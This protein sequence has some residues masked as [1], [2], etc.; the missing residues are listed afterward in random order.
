MSMW[1]IAVG[2]FY[3]ILPTKAIIVGPFLAIFGGECVLQSTIIT[4]TSALAG[5]YVQRYV[6]VQPSFSNTSLIHCRASYFSY[7]SSTSYVVSFMG[8]TLASITMSWNIWL[9]F[10]I[11]I[12]LLVCAIPII[13]LLP[14]A[15]KSIVASTET[16][17]FSHSAERD[18]EEVGPLLA[19]DNEHSPGRYASAFEKPQGFLQETVHAIR[20]LLGLIRGRRNFQILLCSFFLT[21]LASSDTKLLV[22]YISK[23]YD[24]TFAQVRDRT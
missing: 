22:Q 24:W 18:T 4:L 16:A 3:H 19:D 17:S 15:H 12:F 2:Y 13:S 10:S 9:P 11:N 20:K 1:A 8:P 6:S 23:R 7:I 5:E 21:A 14:D